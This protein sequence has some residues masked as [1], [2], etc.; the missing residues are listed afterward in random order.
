MFS[1]QHRQGGLGT[2]E[3]CEMDKI[4]KPGFLLL[5]P[6]RGTPPSGTGEGLGQPC[7]LP[8]LVPHLQE[9]AKGWGDPVVCLP[10]LSAGQACMGQTSE[11][12]SSL[13]GRQR[14]L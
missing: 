11:K 1:L 7:G 4:S 12:L 3:P 6:E 14:K 10:L 13:P 5:F 9:L 8:F 2:D